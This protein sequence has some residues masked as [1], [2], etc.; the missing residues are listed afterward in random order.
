MLISELIKELEDWKEK[1]GDV[2]VV[3]CQHEFLEERVPVVYVTRMGQLCLDNNIVAP[4][5]Y[6]SLDCG[7][8][9]R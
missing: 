8:L 7:D 2:E 3:T 1:E 6:L 9:V 4:H 5:T